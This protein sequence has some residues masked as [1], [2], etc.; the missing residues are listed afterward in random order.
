MPSL[1]LFWFVLSILASIIVCFLMGPSY[2]TILFAPLFF[3]TVFFLGLVLLNGKSDNNPSMAGGAS[4]RIKALPPVYLMYALFAVATLI[5]L[6]TGQPQIEII[7]N[8]QFASSMKDQYLASPIALLRL[9]SGLIL[10]SILPGYAVCRNFFRN[11]SFAWFERFG[12]SIA[13]SFCIS[14]LFGLSF[15]VLGWDL[16][17]WGV[18]IS[19]WL[20][21]FVI[22][23]GGRFAKA[24]NKK[25]AI[26]TRT[27][28]TVIVLLALLVILVGSYG[29]T[30]AAGPASGIAGGDIADYFTTANRFVH[31][32]YV[33]SYI[34]LKFY[35]FLSSSVT[36]LPLAYVYPALQFMVLL[37]PISVYL[38]LKGLFSESKVA[39]IGA[40]FVSVMQ[41][42]SSLPFI[43]ANFSSLDVNNFILNV[44][45]GNTSTYALW[46]STIES[47]LFIFAIAFL[48]KYVISDK[49]KLNYLF[50]GAL[51]LVG[52]LYS[53]FLFLFLCFVGTMMIYTLLRP[54][55]KMRLLELVGAILM[56]LVPF[57][58]LTRGPVFSQL[59]IFAIEYTYSR[60]NLGGQSVLTYA[61]VVSAALAVYSTLL[62]R[63]ELSRKLGI[64]GKLRI[65][66]PRI[67]KLQISYKILFLI[68]LSLVIV[69]ILS[70]YLSILSAYSK[71][72]GTT[73]IQNSSPI[74]NDWYIWILYYGLG[75]PLIFGSIFLIFKRFNKQSLTLL[76]SLLLSVFGLALLFLVAGPTAWA[77]PDLLTKRYLFFASVPLGCFAALGLVSLFTALKQEDPCLQFKLISKING[78]RFSLQRLKS[79]KIFGFLLSFFLIVSV[80]ASFLS[81]VYVDEY[82]TTTQGG[83]FSGAN[84]SSSDAEVLGWMRN[85]LPPNATVM[86]LSPRSY[87]ELCSILTGK[88][89]PLFFDVQ[90]PIG[91][92]WP[93]RIIM[94]SQIPEAIYYSLSKL[95]INYVF[96]GNDSLGHELDIG[97]TTSAFSTLLNTYTYYTN[98]SSGNFVSIGN[99]IVFNGSRVIK[100]PDNYLF[101]DSNYHLV[102]EMWDS[103][104]LL[105]N[106]QA[107]SN[108]FLSEVLLGYENPYTITPIT[109]LATLKPGNVYLFAKSQRLPSSMQSNLLDELSN[110]AHVIFADPSFSSLS[111]IG[112]RTKLPLEITNIKQVNTSQLN[113][114]SV[115]FSRESIKSNF[116]IS[117]VPVMVGSSLQ[118]IASFTLS[119]NST[120]PF[121]VRQKVGLGSVTF[122]NLAPLAESL[123]YQQILQFANKEI[124]RDLPIPVSSNSP[125]V[126]PIPTQ[127][128]DAFTGSTLESWY[129]RDLLN[130]LL[131]DSSNASL[132]GQVTATSEVV[133]LNCSDPTAIS[134]LKIT[135]PDES[136]FV[137]NITQLEIIGDGLVKTTMQSNVTIFNDP[138]GYYSVVNING[139][140]ITL[141]LQ[142][143]RLRYRLD[144][145]SALNPEQVYDFSN[146]KIEAFSFPENITLRLLQPVFRVNGNL[147]SALQGAFLF[148]DTFFRAFS[149]S[150]HVIPGDFNLEVLYASGIT[151]TKITINSL[152]K[153]ELI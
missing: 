139:S 104:A 63:T 15:V 127:L 129:N 101:E 61:L 31:L 76:I 70:A 121:I 2:L 138:T 34:G 88:V 84:I 90:P 53:H 60:G 3:L 122:V 4:E 103:S 17:T 91:D 71:E 40:L 118:T 142:N 39:A 112:Q 124:F 12:L 89:V 98:H 68:G 13:I 106:D 14:L 37:V 30:L 41:G 58:F 134:N 55:S 97:N 119:D 133:Y 66:G 75:V 57:E 86:A 96:D 132:K 137:S 145:D 143:A 100:I 110:G 22:E 117:S 45:A 47:G 115:N 128:F 150:D 33:D 105:V 131:L 50:V 10:L 114:T 54:V 120:I 116:S 123:N 111:E 36:G 108:Y 72:P 113:V 18:I 78:R 24:E 44:E 79:K 52:A 102:S 151:F 51:L 16:S 42:L 35:L 93:R 5:V 26:Q 144:S 74:Y 77:T 67:D 62:F 109:N 9:V 32:D 149:Q 148:Q 69:A 92:I 147:T 56:L 130:N 48:F 141:D 46:V 82:W 64:S 7:G 125:L 25:S 94:D 135:T 6:V 21:V 87:N 29:I 27:V 1:K 107:P 23:F 126:L 11:D 152:D 81:Y 99:K 95:G 38:L 43:I 59:Q 49:R 20:F 73:S 83:L 146:L 28:E 136:F 8:S 153:Y 65:N 85:N 19:L 80:A 140:A